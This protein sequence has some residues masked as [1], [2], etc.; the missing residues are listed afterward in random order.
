MKTLGA[1]TFIGLVL[2]FGTAQA[3]EMMDCTDDSMMKIQADVDAM[4][5]A[6]QSAQK[7]MAMKELEKAKEAQT[8][9]SEADCKAHLGNASKALKKS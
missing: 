4:T 6:A 2:M 7:K 9:N 1:T 8:A 3:Q 5:D